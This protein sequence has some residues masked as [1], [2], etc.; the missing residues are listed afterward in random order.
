M[1]VIYAFLCLPLAHR[2]RTSSPSCSAPAS[3][4]T[5]TSSWPRSATCALSSRGSVSLAW[6][7]WG[8]TLSGTSQVPAQTL[9]FEKLLNGIEQTENLMQAIRI[10]PFLHWD[11]HT[12]YPVLHEGCCF[13]C[14][15]LFYQGNLW[16][17]VLNRP[18]SALWSQRQKF[19]WPLSLLH[20]ESKIIL[21]SLCPGQP[22]TT[23]SAHQ[24]FS[25]CTQFLPI[26][27]SACICHGTTEICHFLCWEL[28][29]T[30]R[31]TNQCLALRHSW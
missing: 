29:I 28:V 3:S 7:R 15:A 13:C 26:R 4:C 14:I 9:L 18:K 2:G 19:C 10:W 17:R 23:T 22:L 11:F 24:P 6:T 1:L 16:N 20:Q 12:A 31:N 30:Y 21:G 8:P 5:R 27:C 25:V